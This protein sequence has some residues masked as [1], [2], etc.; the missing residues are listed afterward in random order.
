MTRF[1]EEHYAKKPHKTAKVQGPGDPANPFLAVGEPAS[2]GPERRALRSLYFKAQKSH[3]APSKA[4][5]RLAWQD[6]GFG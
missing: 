2:W 1:R 6:Q 5:G 3:K 4:Q